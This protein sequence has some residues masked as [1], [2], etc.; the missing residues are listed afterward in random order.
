MICGLRQI[1]ARNTIPNSSVV[2]RI[3]NKSQ[4]TGSLVDV[5][6]KTASYRNI[7]ET[8]IPT[9]R[10]SVTE[11]QETISHGAQELNISV[12]TLHRIHLTKHLPTD[13]AR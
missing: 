11:S 9:V 1:L 12:A 2:K 8:N 7:S 10:E 5:K 6:H 4:S 3:I 13:H